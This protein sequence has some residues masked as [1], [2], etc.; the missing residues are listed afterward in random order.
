LTALVVLS[1]ILIIVAILVYFNL[2]SPVFFVQERVGK[3][4][5]V[6]KMIKFRSMKDSKD[7]NGNYLSDEER[8]TP[9]GAKLR[10]LSVDELPELI[11]IL[12][13]D[14]SIVGPRP[15]LTQYLSLY[16]EEQSK[17]H[18]VRPGLTGWAQINGRNS[19]T[20]TEKFNLDVWYVK[21]RNLLLDLKII[22][23]TMKKVIIKEGINQENNATMEYFNGSN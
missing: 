7:K 1:P 3:D 6:F 14:M 12:K 17:R 16:S 10:S 20:W 23:L 15:L 19:I 13:G 9:F 5:K 21:N 18:D 2:G 11:N 8:L 22:F 4:N